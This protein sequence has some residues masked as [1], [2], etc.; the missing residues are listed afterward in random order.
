MK[1]LKTTAI[2]Y[3]ASNEMDPYI[4]LLESVVNCAKCDLMGNSI[5]SYAIDQ[6]DPQKQWIFDI[7]DPEEYKTALSFFKHESPSG[8][9][10]FNHMLGS[11]GPVRW[12][13]QY[14]RRY[15][16]AV[17]NYYRVH[18]IDST[19]AKFKLYRAHSKYSTHQNSMQY[20]M[21]YTGIREGF[22]AM[23]GERWRGWYR[24]NRTKYKN[25]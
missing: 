6:D 22:D 12:I 7:N 1:Q 8:Y 9:K 15:K 25:N 17:F 21:P 11:D 24:L 5:I 16:T 18:G 20:I 10:A 4:D 13:E 19:V 23:F 3:S 14:R 2:N